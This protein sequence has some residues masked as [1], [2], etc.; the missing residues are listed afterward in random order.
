MA[1]AAQLDQFA[2]QRWRLDNLYYITDKDGNETRFR[3]WP[4]QEELWDG[5]HY[6]N[7][8][9]KARQRGFSTLIQLWMLDSCV[10][11]KNIQAG[12]IAHTREDA[13]AIFKTKVKYA[14]DRLPEGIRAANSATQD[15]ARHLTFKNGSGIRVGTSLRSGTF[16]YLH[17]SEFGKICAQFPDKAE[18]VITGSFNTVPK[19][20]IIFVESTAEGQAG[21][22]YEMCQTA[23]AK[24][25]RDDRLT[26]LDFKFW[27]FPW[28][29]GAE[30]SLPGDEP[31]PSSFEEYF[32]R[33]NELGIEVDHGQKLWYVKMA[34]TQGDKMKREYPSYPEEAF[35]AAIEGAYYGQHL[36][37][38]DAEGRICNVPHDDALPVET[39]WDL[40]I[41]DNTAIWLAQRTRGGEI[42]LIDYYEN[43]GEALSHYVQW[44][45]SR[46]YTYAV[47]VLPHDARAR[48]MASGKSLQTAANELGRKTTIAPNVSV[49]EGI[50]A[51]RRILGRCWFD[52][53]KCEQ[54]L[55]AMRAYRKEW[56]ESRA[57]WKQ[58]PL[59]DWASHA[60]DAFR[61]G[62][63][64]RGPKA[65]REGKTYPEMAVV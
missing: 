19:D 40:G 49:A 65:K 64:Y 60:A 28:W 8:I 44:L 34:E 46:P 16:Q 59:H 41:S 54:G 51:V 9:L 58:R 32:K 12:V 37:R 7:C 2:D 48:E 56:D 39:W 29:R 43:S 23:Q 21:R 10:F 27:F 3:M 45:E 6:R 15:A 22:F 5:L 38:A 35:E 57:D 17:V 42:H 30:Y 55:K 13:E 25:R 1:T 50:D 14:Y 4:E 11:D 47:D 26:N 62:A 52:K 31:I 20:G 18:E 63:L 61:M 53:G 33:L 24:Q 36:A